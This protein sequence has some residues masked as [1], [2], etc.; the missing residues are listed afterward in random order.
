LEDKTFQA[1]G[2]TENNS[3]EWE[4]IRTTTL[5]FLSLQLL[6]LPPL[7]FINKSLHIIPCSTELCPGHRL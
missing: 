6:P 4:I 7:F 5:T 1:L 2:L 3:R